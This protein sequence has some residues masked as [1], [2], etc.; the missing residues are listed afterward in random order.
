MSGATR[1][2]IR[3]RR[4]AR[5]F[6]WAALIGP[7][8]VALGCASPGSTPTAP[9]GGHTL[10]LGYDEFAQNVEPVLVEH[11][12]DAG[13]DCHGGGI[14][15]TLALSPQG[16]KDVR[17]DFD[18]VSLQVSPTN[19]D[20]SRILLKPLALAAG[21]LPHAVKVFATPSDSGYQAI[22]HWIVDGVLR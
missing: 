11:G 10:V 7:P 15:G 4:A 9:S 1:G 8:L 2:V 14:R 16:A 5:W 20:S 12:C 13:G 6:A 18:Q 22:R 3:G 21:G 17:F 19:P